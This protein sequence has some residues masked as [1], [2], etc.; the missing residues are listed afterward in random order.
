MSVTAPWEDNEPLLLLNSGRWIQHR[1][2]FLYRSTAR[3]GETMVT[4]GRVWS[5][6]T[7]PCVKILQYW[8]KSFLASISNTLRCLYS[9]NIK[10][11]QNKK[12]TCTFKY[13]NY[14]IYTEML[15]S[16][17]FIYHCPASVVFV[18]AVY[19]N[20]VQQ[21][22]TEHALI[23]WSRLHNTVMKVLFSTL[24]WL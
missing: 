23:Q 22:K 3:G 19:C 8:L 10:S 17:M 20:K 15:S 9:G 12:A 24:G 2:W 1:V 14:I 6:S 18:I 13:M 21:Q 16:K 7:D 5:K 4:R 11:L